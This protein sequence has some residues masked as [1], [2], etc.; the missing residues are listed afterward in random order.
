MTLE[1]QRLEQAVSL[2]DSLAYLV[3]LHALREVFHVPWW[4]LYVT[5]GALFAYRFVRYVRTP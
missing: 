5:W 3:G 1:E 2:L 4:C